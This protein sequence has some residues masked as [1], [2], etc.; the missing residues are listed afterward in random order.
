M[1]LLTGATGY[2]GGRLRAEGR[3]TTQECD[4]AI[5]LLEWSTRQNVRTLVGAQLC[6]WCFGVD[7][8]SVQRVIRVRM[9]QPKLND[10]I[11]AVVAERILPNAAKEQFGARQSDHERPN[12]R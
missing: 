12:G 11:R 1:I 3:R 10:A 6:E 8:R 7:D 4:F 5:R 9:M 2:V